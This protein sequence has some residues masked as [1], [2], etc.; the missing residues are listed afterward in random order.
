LSVE[1]LDLKSGSATVGAKGNASKPAGRIIRA[2]EVRFW[3]NGAAYLDE[4]K[5]ALEETH[6][7]IPLIIAEERAKGY[8]EGYDSGA[9]DVIELMARMKAEAENYYAGLGQEIVGLVTKLVSDIIGD[10]T[11]SE[12]VAATVLK[13]VRTLDLGSEFSLYV[14]PEVYDD[15][16][17]RL[18]K[19]L[20]EAAQSKLQLRQDPKLSA[21][22]C[23]LV[24]EFGMVDLSIEKQLD[25]LAAS[26]RAAGVGVKG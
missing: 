9:A 22:D 21:T 23:R 3:E 11:P 17:K 6:K 15:V 10:T 1:R 8:R 7:R 5:Q 18:S 13:A 20:D 24:S 16:G 14:A 12:A 25:I 4:A 26:L 2:D 19:R